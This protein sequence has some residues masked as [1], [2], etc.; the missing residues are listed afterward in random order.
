MRGQAIQVHERIWQIQTPFEGDGMV[1]LYVIRGS[2]LALVD[3]GVAASPSEDLRPGLKSIGLELSDIGAILNTHGH[4]DHAGGN[5]D[6]KQEAPNAEIHMH[7]DDR[8]FADSHEYHRTFMTNFLHQFGRS[9][10]VPARQAVFARTLGKG[11]AGIDRE[12][13]DGDRVDLGSGVV[14]TVIHS[15]GHTPGSVCFYWESEKLL[16]SGD[17][18]QARGSRNGGYPLYFNSAT[19]RRTVERLLDVDAQTLCLGH[20]FHSGLHLNWPVKHGEEV[21]HLLEESARVTKLIHEAVKAR[22]DANPRASNLEIAQG[23]ALDLID[24]I[25][26]MLDPALRLPGAAATL[27]A[28][29]EELRGGA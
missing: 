21:K 12:L 5:W 23:A 27:W 29:I 10:L 9:D 15:P 24:R 1:M 19:Y 25:P 8:G 6:F 4:H 13:S 28:H 20:G 16:L 14:L 11:D 17:S 3:T 22:L 7:G 2:K 26:V 18:V